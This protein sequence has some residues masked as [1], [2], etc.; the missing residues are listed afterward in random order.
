LIE[1]VLEQFIAADIFSLKILQWLFNNNGG[2]MPFL[3][4]PWLLLCGKYFGMSPK[5]G[6]L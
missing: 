6:R 4:S 5:R 3:P 1:A 2:Q